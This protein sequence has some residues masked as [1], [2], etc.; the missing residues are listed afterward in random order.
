MLPDR[1][2]W[3]DAA[4]RRDHRYLGPNDHCLYFGEFLAGSGW[5]AGAIN[6]L[7]SDFKRSPS[8][9]AASA[10]ALAVQHFKDRAIAMVARALRRQFAR[11]SVEAVLTFV[12]IPPSKIPGEP[13]HCDRL[14]RTLEL[15]FAGLDA[16]IRPL[17]RQRASTAAD[18]ESRARRLR[19]AE[20]IELTELDP[21]HLERRPRP[22]LVLFD[23]V[24]TTGKHYR[25]CE[26]RLHEALPQ[27][28]IC[29]WFI[30]RRALPAVRRAAEMPVDYAK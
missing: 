9:I 15:A 16:D 28:P 1:L 20:L 21:A 11:S 2:T 12:P 3:N 30:A 25:C 22:L 23:D 17:L 14:R 13:D 5:R 8:A 18:H 29:G 24:L 26:R 6:D 27:V 10:S 19:F 4:A 7:I